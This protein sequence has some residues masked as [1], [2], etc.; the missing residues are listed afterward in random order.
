MEATKLGSSTKEEIKMAI[1]SE[2]RPGS[3]LWGSILKREVLNLDD[4]ERE[5]RS[6]YVWKRAI[7]TSMPKKAN[8][9]LVAILPICLG[10]PYRTGA[11]C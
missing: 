6:T 4:F 3:K 11:S 2:V 1:T 8:L 9:P 7:R 5:H 10:I